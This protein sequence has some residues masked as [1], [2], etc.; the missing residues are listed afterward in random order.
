M[1]QKEQQRG[2]CVASTSSAAAAV[3]RSTQTY[4]R[5]NTAA[6]DKA[7]Y[8]PMLRALR[9]YMLGAAVMR[10]KPLEAFT[11]LDKAVAT[12]IYKIAVCCCFVVVWSLIAILIACYKQSCLTTLYSAF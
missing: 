6:R 11:T 7:Y 12:T 3:D 2:N 4:F 10:F 1:P 5:L 8:I 9:I